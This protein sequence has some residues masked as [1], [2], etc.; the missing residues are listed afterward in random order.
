MPPE[1]AAAAPS[2][3]LVP[4][5][6]ADALTALDRGD[7]E[8]HDAAAARHAAT[9]ADCDVIALAQF[10][11]ARATDAVA[12]ATGRPVLSTPDSAV[13]KLKRLLAP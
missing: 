7:T 3:T 11:L 1:F 8:G 4:R 6:A 5:L 10:S 9:L 13:R 2:A 12:A